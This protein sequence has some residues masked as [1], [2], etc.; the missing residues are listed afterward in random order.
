MNLFSLF[1]D[2]SAPDGRLRRD[3]RRAERRVKVFAGRAG[4]ALGS[5]SRAAEGLQSGLGKILI[6]VAL[7]GAISGIRNQIIATK[8]ASDAFVK[9]LRDGTRDAEIELAKAAG[10]LNEIQAATIARRREDEK[11]VDQLQQQA[12]NL[13]GL[14]NLYQIAVSQLTGSLTINQKL[15]AALEAQNDQAKL[16]SDTLK[17]QANEAER[18]AEAED[19]S[20]RLQTLLGLRRELTKLQAD[21]LDAEKRINFE[22]ERRQQ[23]LLNFRRENTG[24]AQVTGLV[25]SIVELER[26]R[27]DERI[28]QLSRVE[29]AERESIQRNA[30]F[31]QQQF[32]QAF[33]SAT[34]VFGDNSSGSIQA[35]AR[36]LE[37]SIVQLTRVSGAR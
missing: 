5:A 33:S 30:Q 29:A 19:R 2:I 1:V 31:A 26:K 28:R 8:N 12:E 32:S 3:L 22:F 25:N 35:L 6:P 17:I 18:L 20:E 27:A 23:Q 16:F 9:S 13:N 36:R 21:E 10:R 14:S 34:Q 4:Q 11:V 24:D 37:A 15:T 7:V